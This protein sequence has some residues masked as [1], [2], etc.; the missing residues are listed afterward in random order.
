MRYAD[1]NGK[2][3]N[4]ANDKDLVYVNLSVPLGSNSANLYSRALKVGI[5]AG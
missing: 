3:S 4:T 2:D 5:N 1:G